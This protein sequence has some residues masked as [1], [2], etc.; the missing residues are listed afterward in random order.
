[1]SRF[2]SFFL[3]LFFFTWV[4]IGGTDYKNKNDQFRVKKS[5]TMLILGANTV[6]TL[7]SLLEMEE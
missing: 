5:K 1:M 6:V 2:K 4:T 3:F 7:K